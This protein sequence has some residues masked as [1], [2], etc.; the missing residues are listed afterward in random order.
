[1]NDILKTVR[2]ARRT[3]TALAPYGRP[4]R[5][6][7]ISGT[8]ATL[9][10]V[11]CRLAFPWPLRGL[12]EIV[13]HRGT[14]AN[15]VVGLVPH[16]GDPVWWLVGSFVA[17]ILLW[18]LSES[19]QRLSF[20]R[21]A[22]GLVRDSRASA[23]A[24]IPAADDRKPGDL[25]SAVTGDAARVK[26]GVK[27]IL[28]GTSRNGAFFVGVTIIIWLIDPLIGLIFL[29]GGI[30]TMLVGALGAWRSSPIAKRSRKRESG[31]TQ[32]LHRYFRGKAELPSRTSD[33]TQRPDSKVTRIEAMTTFGV[34]VVL[35]VSTCAILVLAIDAGR[36]GTLSPGSVFTILAY[37]MLM[38]NK[39]VGFGRRIV[40][41]GRLLPSAERL[42][43]LATKPVE[44]KP[45]AAAPEPLSGRTDTAVGL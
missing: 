32:N 13:F 21:F 31:L 45:P 27:S 41:G 33:P 28:I 20:T 38:H 18:G 25:I 17:I 7:L 15:G 44:R 39:T 12:M 3:Y 43:K 36:D 8:A 2:R 9:V 30:A 37:I 5:R 10:L 6:Q 34:H 42:A 23:L 4:H 16:T 24:Q 19:F 26:S 40:R 35:A 29:V 11:A 14:R 1:M 22:V